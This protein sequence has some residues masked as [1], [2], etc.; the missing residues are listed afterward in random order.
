MR[1]LCIFLVLFQK[2]SVTFT[3][4]EYGKTRIRVLALLLL[5]PMEQI[6]WIKTKLA[7]TR[8]YQKVIRALAVSGR[9]KKST[10]H[11]ILKFLY[12]LIARPWLF[13]GWITLS[14]G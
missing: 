8:S 6:N 13:K 9:E 10:I 2:C 3:A 12:S 11:F 5:K 1:S 7:L 14:T 4:I